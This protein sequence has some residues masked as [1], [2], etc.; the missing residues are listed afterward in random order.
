MAAVPIAIISAVIAAGTGIASHQQQARAAEKQEEA[1]KLRERI[2]DIRAQRE[3]GRQIRAQRIA[4]AQVLSQQATSGTS[5]T[6][7]SG[8]ISSTQSQLS[9]NLSFLDLSRSTQGNIFDLEQSAQ[10]NRTRAN[11]FTTG[12]QAVS[13]IAGQITG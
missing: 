6:G 4:Q 13:T 5:G 7:T 9:S 12:G 8:L 11:I 10:R 2:A 3:K 1:N